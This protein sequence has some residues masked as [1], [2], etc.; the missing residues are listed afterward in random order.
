MNNRLFSFV[1]LST[2]LWYAAG[3]AFAQPQS[4]VKEFVAFKNFLQN[5]QAAD[6]FEFT[7]PGSG[8]KDTAAFEEMRRHILTMYSGIEVKHSFVLHSDHFDCVP[9]AQQPTVKVLSLKNIASA[10][11]QSLLPEPSAG[12]R[13]EFQATPA[14]QLSA[15]KQTDEFGNSVGCE[16]NT[17]P[18]R[19][20]TLEEMKQFPTLR[21]YF[22]KGPNGAGRPAIL[23]DKGIPV[24]P[25]NAGHKYSIMS[26]QVDNLGG[27]S[28]LNLWSP[29][30]DTAWGEVFSLSQEWYVGGNGPST[31]T[32]EV[33]WQNY[34]DF[35]GSEDSRLFIYWTADNYNTTGCYNLTCPAFVQ[36]SS[37]A[38]LG[39]K[40]ANYSTPGGAQY[41]FSA[42]Y[43]LYQG[44]WWLSFQ[45][46]WI[47]YYPGA[48]YGGGQLSQYAQLM[49]FGTESVGNTV[50]PGEG[51]SFW[52]STGFGFAAYQRNLYYNY[53]SGA[54]FW[55]VLVH[56]DPS[57][58]CY[59]TWEP[60]F[61]TSAG[62]GVYF[63]EG[64]PGGPGC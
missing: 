61:S 8:V 15:E 62:W 45:G 29:Y 23:N 46:T 39:G 6:S 42:R 11:P 5:T 4:R 20:I 26:Q 38:I 16:Q 27:N 28:S 35:Y 12:D 22:Q 44:N 58:S 51:S 2:V 9:I 43:Y 60:P 49:Q 14:T 10:P 64:G 48:I 24:A 1:A 41:D 36:V 3:T 63:Y 37:S 47:G 7:R 19:R 34:P 50:W 52:S 56:I 57:P 25:S 53:V 17:I 55:D 54:A 40:F 33:G 18:M 59:S 31:Q 30:V 21:E 13:S 32:A